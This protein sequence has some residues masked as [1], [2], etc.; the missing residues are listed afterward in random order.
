MAD[1]INKL[2]WYSNTAAELNEKHYAG[3]EQI[4]QT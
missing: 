3:A 1:M 4:I 2:P